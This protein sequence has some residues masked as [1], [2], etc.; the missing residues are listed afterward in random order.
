MLQRSR[1]WKQIEYKE[2]Q[3][4]E[5]IY[6]KVLRGQVLNFGGGAC[7]GKPLI[8]GF[9]FFFPK[10]L[11]RGVEKTFWGKIRPPNIECG[12]ALDTNSSNSYIIIHYIT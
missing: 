2:N 7:Y 11:I 1:G 8:Y 9:F 3:L 4:S 6:K 5:N 12:S 10:P